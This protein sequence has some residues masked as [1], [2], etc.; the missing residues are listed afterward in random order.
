MKPVSLFLCLILFFSCNY[1]FAQRPGKPK[2]LKVTGDYSH[3]VTKTVF[4]ET[5]EGLK[6]V[7]VTAF[8]KPRHDIGVSY[9]NEERGGKTR[10]SIFIYPVET[11]T[12]NSFR[13]QYNLC[14]QSLAYVASRELKLTQQYACIKKDGYTINGYT[15]CFNGDRNTRQALELYQ[16]GQW[17]MELRITSN[18]L[19][20]GAIAKLNRS[21]VNQLDPVAIVKAFPL[22]QK[23]TINIAPAAF[24]DSLLLGCTIGRTLAK[25]IWAKDNV[26]SMEKLS[27]FPELYL[28]LYEAEVNGFLH[29]AD[30]NTTMKVYPEME[31]ILSQLRALRAA[32]YLDE[33]IMDSYGLVMIVPSDR[34]FD[35]AGYYKWKKE[36]PID[37]KLTSRYY[38]VEYAPLKS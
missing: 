28:G 5:L 6:R 1:T 25:L 34:K 20:T 7:E 2:K 19:D 24:S 17:F 31:N 15:A 22:S 30:T 18:L 38:I 37:F 9:E 29:F 35:S 14:L 3:I 8:D 11:A 13:E 36:H 27:G 10:L 21:V 23:A 16:C 12:D 26:D 4:P 32:G 33:F